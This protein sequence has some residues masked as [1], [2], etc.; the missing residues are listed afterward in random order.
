[1]ENKLNSNE[2]KRVCCRTLCN[3]IKNSQEINI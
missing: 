2:L 3:P 1:M